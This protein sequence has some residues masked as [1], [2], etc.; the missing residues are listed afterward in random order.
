MYDNNSFILPK[1]MVIEHKLLR[2]INNNYQSDAASY[3]E[4]YEF[5]EKLEKE[6]EQRVSHLETLI[7]KTHVKIKEK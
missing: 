2:Q 5:W 1:Q 4:F 6:T 3:P 7:K